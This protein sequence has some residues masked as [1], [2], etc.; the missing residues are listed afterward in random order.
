[1]ILIENNF[2]KYILPVTFA[3]P[4]KNGQSNLAERSLK[5]WNAETL[6]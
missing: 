5:V 2:V 6:K 1:V 3:L 4:L